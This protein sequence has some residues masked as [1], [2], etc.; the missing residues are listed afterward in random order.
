MSFNSTGPL[1]H[2]NFAW[3][4]AGQ[5]ASIAGNGI[6][7]VALPLEVLRLTGNPFDLALVLAVDQIPTVLL[8]LI[9]GALV[10][11]ISR[12]LIMLASDLVNGAVLLVLTLLIVTGQ[13]ALWHMLLFAFLSGTAIAVYLPASS[14]IVADILPPPL[15]AA[16]NSMMSLSQSVGQFLFGPLVG[17]VIVAVFG[18]DWGFGIDALTFLASA[19]CL[20]M[21]RGLAAVLGTQKQSSVLTDVKVGLGY[22][23]SRRWLWWNMIAIG[24]ANLAAYLPLFVVLPLL[25]THSFKAGSVAL[26]L[27]YAG[28]GLGGVAAS[29]Y[30]KRSKTPARPLLTMWV[31]LAVG[32]LS[33]CLVGASPVIPLAVMFSA[34]MWAAVTYANIVWFTELQARV[35]SALLGRIMSLDL[36]FSIALGPVAF[37]LGGLGA[38][39][40]GA[41]ATMIAGGLIATATAVVAFVPRVLE[42]D[43]LPVADP[44]LQT[45]SA[46]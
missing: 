41:R 33:V 22:T 29:I 40:F 46:S 32:S 15:L 11:R 38:D 24:I 36:L 18:I 13:L 30:G 9:G 45:Q 12:R 26:G 34:T 25:V 6:F 2:R 8:L 31:T 19:G 21:I 27:I 17:G 3:F 43:E 44:A 35:P 20:A 4:W 23:R 7:K 37:F 42:P 39:Q 5:S 16:G 1:R 28:S 10:D 14:A